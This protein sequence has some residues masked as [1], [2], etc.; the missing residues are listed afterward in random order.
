MDM[1]MMQF[2]V[3]SFLKFNVSRII[4]KQPLQLSMAKNMESGAYFWNFELWHEALVAAESEK[5]N[6][7]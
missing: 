6:L 4:G 1:A 7:K 2:V 5:N 3:T